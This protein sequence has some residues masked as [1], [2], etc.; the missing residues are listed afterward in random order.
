MKIIPRNAHVYL[1]Q[2]KTKANRKPLIIRGAR[3]VGKTTLVEEFGKQFDRF[4]YL[5]L[6]RIEHANLFSD[7]LSY[8]QV[9]ERIFLTFPSKK[10]KKN[11]SV[12][13]F[14]DEIQNQPYAIELLRYF[15]EQNPELAV[16]AAGSLLEHA[17]NKSISFP[18]GRV[19]YYYLNPLGFDEF[20]DGIGA[21]DLAR[22]FRERAPIP[23]HLDDLYIAH[24]HRYAQVGGMPGIVSEFI[25]SETTEELSI[26]YESILT[27]YID[28]VEKYARNEKIGKIIRETLIAIFRN[29][30]ERISLENF[31]GLGHKWRVMQE[32][33]TVLENTLLFLRIYPLTHLQLPFS[34]NRK[35]APRL[36]VL[37]TGLLNYFS[38]W[39]AEMI[40]VK[41]L[42]GFHKGRVLQHIVGQELLKQEKSRISQPLHFWVK[43]KKTSNA[44]VDFIMYHKGKTI[45]IEVKGGNSGRLRSLHECMDTLDHDIAIRLYQGKKSIDHITSRTGKA[46]R[47]LSFP[48]YQAGR[49]REELEIILANEVI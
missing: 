3:Q 41:D 20:L 23:P 38:G 18:V 35:R 33:F 11:E 49:I 43:E 7:E 40:G 32:V 39:F 48:Y 10:N 37:D 14:I 28:D 1:D 13:V 30:G 22:I 29:G 24:F 6:E 12:L 9:K 5:N 27:S 42:S 36:Q 45:P 25:A 16:I 19:E 31:G 46:Y 2:W 17:I 4:I 21:E 8:E 34:P 26:L 44:E 47:L 15:Y